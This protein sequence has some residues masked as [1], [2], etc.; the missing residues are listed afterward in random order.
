MKGQCKIPMNDRIR[1]SRAQT[2]KHRFTREELARAGR[3]TAGKTLTRD[4]RVKGGKATGVNKRFGA[5][6][7]WHVRRGLADT[8]CPFCFV[9]WML[10]RFS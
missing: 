9:E 5:H 10:K 7:R 4:A 3:A 8:A 6:N 2:N 1:G